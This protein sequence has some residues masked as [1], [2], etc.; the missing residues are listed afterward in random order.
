[1][2]IRVLLAAIPIW[3]LGC[4][5]APQP[6]AAPPPTALP[7]AE[8]SPMV[9]WF[10]GYNE[11]LEGRARSYD[12]FQRRTL[13]LRARVSGVRCVGGA[14][15]RIVPPDAVPDERC[16]GVLGT[17]MLTCSDEREIALEWS[18]DE[19]CATGYGR[20]LDREGNPVRL[21]FGGSA[22]RAETIA[23]EALVDAGRRPALPA[24]GSAHAEGQ[25]VSTGTAFFVSFDG[26]LLTNHHVISQAKR[27][28]VALDGGELVEAEIVS[29]DEDNDLAVLRVDAIRRPLPLRRK[30]ALLKGDEVIALGYPL[31]SMQGQEQK[32]TFGHVNALS[33][34]Q[35]DER[36]TQVDVPI[37][38]GNSGGP[39]LN[40]RGEVV[41]VMTSM[42]HPLATLQLAGVVP[43]NVNYALKVDLAHRMMSR[44]LGKDWKGAVAGKALLELGEV[45]RQSESSVVLVVAE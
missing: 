10:E 5:A 45:V 18:L 16:G 30:H 39:L 44:S 25:G 15:V 42:L 23:E 22:T 40:M 8:D 43:Q 17:A 36:F 3:L 32:A 12:F 2:T 37:Q 26:H 34:L 20:G 29:K 9:L 19:S 24:P 6:A 21:V 14:D 41:G 35:G 27:V 13:D 31:V 33:G 28:Q 38:P 4:V 7:L 1:M 11:V